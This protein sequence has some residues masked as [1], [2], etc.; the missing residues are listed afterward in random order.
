MKAVDKDYEVLRRCAAAGVT[1]NLEEA[2]QLRRIASTLRRW[3]ELECGVDADG[4]T[5]CLERDEETGKPKL[6]RHTSRGQSYGWPTPDREK[7][8]RKRLAALCE[9]IP[10]SAYIQTDPRGASLYIGSEALDHNN[11]HRA[12]C[13]DL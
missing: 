10:C 1:V 12:A 2:R 3:F 9:A 6:Y 5:L 11:Y 8:A 7:G 4:D 13:C